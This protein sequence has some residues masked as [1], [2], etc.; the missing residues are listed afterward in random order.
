MPMSKQEAGNFNQEIVASRGNKLLRFHRS[1]TGY[2]T[3]EVRWRELL[4][5]DYVLMGLGEFEFRV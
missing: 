4:I 1:T 3:F 2:S 5:H